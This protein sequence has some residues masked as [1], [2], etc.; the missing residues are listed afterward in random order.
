MSSQSQAQA[1]LLSIRNEIKPEFLSKPVSEQ[2]KILEY[3]YNQI[4]SILKAKAKK[5]LDLL[6]RAK[7]ARK[8]GKKAKKRGKKRGQ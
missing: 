3:M 5:A 1:M 2:E 8:K 4:Q 6:K 7:K